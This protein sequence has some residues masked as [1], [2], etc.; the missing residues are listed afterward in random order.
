M[1][2]YFHSITISLLYFFT[3]PE[4]A[5]SI[6]SQ[7]PIDPDKSAKYIF[8]MHGSAEESDGDNEKYQAAVEAIAE[9][10]ATVITE[11]R[12]DTDPNA[13]AKNIK[14]Q[15]EHLLGKG[16][17]AKN[18]SVTGFSKGAV[19]SLAVANIMNNAEINYVLLAGCSEDPV[20][21][22]FFI[23]AADKKKFPSQTPFFKPMFLPVKGDTLRYHL[24]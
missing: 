16:V 6:I 13:Y 7:I 15:V 12:G 1:N 9:S 23:Y 2:T 19:I 8:Y 21:L 24:T 4:I 18:I 22:F 14:Q 10:D 3:L 17:P 5:G 11:V 20:D